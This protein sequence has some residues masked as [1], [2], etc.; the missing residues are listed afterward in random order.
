MN[1][2]ASF[3]IRGRKLVGAAVALTAIGLVALTG[4][5]TAS[6]DTRLTLKPDLQIQSASYECTPGVPYCN[7]VRLRVVIKNGGFVGSAGSHVRITDQNGMFKQAIYLAPLAAGQSVTVLHDLPN[8]DCGD[9]HTRIVKADGYNVIDE[10]IESNN[11]ATRT[12]IYPAC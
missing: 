7:A 2:I 9:A 12:Y 5:S 6:A 3:V 8:F 10:L 1:K 4:S 11:T